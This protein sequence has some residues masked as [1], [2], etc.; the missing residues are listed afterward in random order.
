[1]LH[2][3]LHLETSMRPTE[4]MKLSSPFRPFPC[5]PTALP[6][7]TGRVIQADTPDRLPP[8]PP[9]QQAIQTSPSIVAALLLRTPLGNNHSLLCP[10]HGLHLRRLGLAGPGLHGFHPNRIS[11]YVRMLI[12][13][14]RIARF[15]GQ[16]YRR[17]PVFFLLCPCPHLSNLLLNSFPSYSYGD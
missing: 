5:V 12:G 2:L 8:S 13:G 3:N 9:L 16:R 6:F 11:W 15:A 10:P 4:I 1:M 17:Y 7:C 14:L